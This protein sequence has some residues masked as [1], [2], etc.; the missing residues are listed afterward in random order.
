MSHSHPRIIIEP[1]PQDWLLMKI[2][3]PA[4]KDEMDHHGFGP[5]IFNTEP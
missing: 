1:S 3:D 5:Q 4:L 2:E